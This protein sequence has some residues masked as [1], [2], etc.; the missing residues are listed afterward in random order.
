MGFEWSTNK[1]RIYHRKYFVI[2]IAF[3][4]RKSPIKESS[5]NQ[6]INNQQNF[7]EYLFHPH[8]SELINKNDKRKIVK[9]NRTPLQSWLQ[10]FDAPKIAV[11]KTSSPEAAKIAEQIASLFRFVNFLSKFSTFEL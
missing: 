11:S 5:E 3:I 7:K 2:I 4:F 9:G 8:K 10:E 1:T 6:Q